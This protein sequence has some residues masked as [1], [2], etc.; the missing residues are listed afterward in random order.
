M[1]PGKQ[2]MKV[3]GRWIYDLSQNNLH[4]YIYLLVKPLIRVAGTIVV[5]RE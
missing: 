4:P 5:V 3:K 1:G 2:R